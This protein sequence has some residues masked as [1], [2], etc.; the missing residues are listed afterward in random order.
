MVPYVDFTTIRRLHG[1]RQLR[2][3]MV[4]W[5]AFYTADL[6]H[7]TLAVVYAFAAGGAA[8]VGGATVLNVLP[9]G[10][11]G[12]FVTML[13]ASP[14]PQVH[15][16]I[17]NGGRALMMV[18]TAFAILNGM[19]VAVVLALVAAD[20]LVSAAV[21]PLQGALIVRLADSVAEAA[22]ANGATSFLVN[23]SALIGPALAGVTL[24]VV[25]IGWAFALPAGI[26]VIAMLSALAIRPPAADEDDD[27]DEQM[28]TDSVR[29]QLR[30]VGVGFRAI[31]ASRPAAAAT[32]L[33]LLN[34]TLMGVWWVA[35][36]PLAGEQ[37]G[38]GENGITTMI[39]LDGAGGLVG[40]LVTL[41]V[42]G[43]KRLS[44][45][46]VEGMAALALLTALIGTIVNPT[47]GLAVAFGVGG[48]GAV[49]YAI[50]P[51]LVQRSVTPSAMVP[52]AA[53]LQSLYLVGVGV[54]GIVAPI[55]I[56]SVG[57]TLM[58]AILGA[59]TVVTALVAWPKLIHADVLDPDDAGKLTVIR[60]TPLLAPLPA[61]TLEQLARAA[62]RL[63]E[64][65]G[66]VVIHQGDHGDRF[67]MIARGVADV[68]VDGRRVAALG[69][70]GSFG[71]IALLHEVPRSATVTAR[72][73]LDL[74]VVDRPKFLG[75]LGSDAGAVTRLGG[76]ARQRLDTL[77]VEERLSELDRDEAL[78]DRSLVETLAA[79][80]PL[81]S[82]SDDG[83]RELADAARVVAAPDGSMITREGDHG[84]TYYVILSGAVEVL[85]G[86]SLLH[87]LRPG[88]GFGEQAIMRNVPQPSTVRALGY[89]TLVAID[90]GAFQRAWRGD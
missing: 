58:L 78:G 59:V 15:L 32:S 51:T 90:R 2:A 14:R 9:G 76:L 53:S 3:L 25:G 5:A 82:I 50:A 75:A 24:S 55:M 65:A 13:G 88:S 80:P 16:A 69:P 49:A 1:N 89:T 34:M 41:S 73:D 18:A 21:R 54:G 10:L 29:T 85:R 64:P 40:A 19:P 17:G 8:A 7:F 57:V 31:L 87:N 45:M 62:T 43:R 47:L 27:D 35:I 67:Y 84:D 61:K 71:E 37:L 52:A 36:A 6:A 68:T 60:G 70:G 26:F 42:V 28:S 46:L 22:A 38:L 33:F 20:S 81:A 56:K 77:P 72:E 12:P 79:Q 23:A 86:E 4:G 63:V 48:A 44:R 30:A 83:L 39:T 66:A 11:I 74:V